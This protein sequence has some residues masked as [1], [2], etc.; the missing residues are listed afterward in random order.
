[1]IPASHTQ[2]LSGQGE[3]TTWYLLLAH[4]HN[5]PLNVCSNNSGREMCI[6]STEV[7]FKALI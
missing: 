6:Y 1:M 7:G 5:H 2:V 3:N 4:V